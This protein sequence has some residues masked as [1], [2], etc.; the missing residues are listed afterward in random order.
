[1]TKGERILTGGETPAFGW[2]DAT[3]AAQVKK[4]VSAGTKRRHSKES[5]GVSER[6]EVPV[7]AV[8]RPL[9]IKKKASPDEVL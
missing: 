1:L 6:D 8:Q 7:P 5:G 3:L 4:N 2:V 9:M